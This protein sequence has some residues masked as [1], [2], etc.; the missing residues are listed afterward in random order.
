M[1]TRL[2]FASFINSAAILVASLGAAYAIGL[3]VAAGHYRAFVVGNMVGL[4]LLS[5]TAAGMCLRAYRDKAEPG[6]IFIVFAGLAL[7]GVMLA[8]LHVTDLVFIADTGKRTDARAVELIMAFMAFGLAFMSWPG[9]A[10][11]LAMV[12]ARPR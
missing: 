3:D 11:R 7:G 2:P 5:L 10:R 4:G 12:M 9:F 6:P 1:D 8:A